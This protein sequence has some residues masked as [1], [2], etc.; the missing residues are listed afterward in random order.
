MA[1]ISYYGQRREWIEETRLEKF[2][3]L[4]RELFV[5]HRL[6][7]SGL[8]KGGPNNPLDKNSKVIIFN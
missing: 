2:P 4:S 6:V 1:I 5:T 3:S 8:Q 7:G